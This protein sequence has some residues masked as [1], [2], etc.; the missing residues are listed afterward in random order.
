MGRRRGFIPY[1]TFPSVNRP[2]KLLSRGRGFAL[3]YTFPFGQQARSIMGWRRGLRPLLHFSLRSTSLVCYG[4]EEE[5]SPP[6]TLFPSV[7]GPDPLWSRVGGFTRY[8]YYTST[9]GQRA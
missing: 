1:Y 9:F 3:Y 5:A 4:A 2:D 6:T 7:N 8:V